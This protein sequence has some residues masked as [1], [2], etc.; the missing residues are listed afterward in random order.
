MNAVYVR[1]FTEN[2]PSRA[3]IIAEMVDEAC[4]VEIVARA[5]VGSKG[6]G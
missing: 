4:L 6:L 2:Y 1:Y 5:Y 3:T